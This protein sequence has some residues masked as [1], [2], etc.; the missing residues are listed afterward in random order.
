MSASSLQLLVRDMHV[1]ICHLKGLDMVL[2]PFT[3][4][5]ELSLG[6]ILGQDFL[7]EFQVAI[8]CRERVINFAA[9]PMV[10]EIMG[11]VDIYV[12]TFSTQR[13]AGQKC[14]VSHGEAWTLRM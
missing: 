11:A 4:V 2:W 5:K 1:I 10:S 13:I 14:T 8:D 6:I 7:E 9:P 12:P 3:I